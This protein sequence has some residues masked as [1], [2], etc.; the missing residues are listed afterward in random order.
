MF[1][2]LKGNKETLVHIPLL[3]V[4]HYFITRYISNADNFPLKRHHSSG[5]WP[6]FSRF[7]KLRTVLEHVASTFVTTKCQPRRQKVGYHPPKNISW[8]PSCPWLEVWKILT[9][10]EAPFCLQRLLTH[11]F[12]PAGQVF[13]TV[14]AGPGLSL[15]SAWRCSK[16]GLGPGWPASWQSGWRHGLVVASALHRLLVSAET[17]KQTKKNSR[18]GQRST[19][20]KAD[21]MR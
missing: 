15:S 21:G 7:L 14:Q 4:C 18:S 17:Y 3:L 5:F 11:P 12:S 20:I 19:E 8:N 6:C 2:A 10:K 13:F 16:T 9:K 1:Q